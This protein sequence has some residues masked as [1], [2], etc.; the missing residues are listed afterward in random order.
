M[1]DKIKEKRL[2]LFV[3]AIASPLKKTSLNISVNTVREYIMSKRTLSRLSFAYYILVGVI[4][5]FVLIKT[6]VNYNDALTAVPLSFFLII[7]AV[8]IGLFCLLGFILYRLAYRFLVSDK[9]AP[10]VQRTRHR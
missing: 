1:H 8:G 10:H 7:D 3:R 4:G 2:I 6:I 5:L 9:E